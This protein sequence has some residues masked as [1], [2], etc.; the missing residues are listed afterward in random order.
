MEVIDGFKELHPSVQFEVSYFPFDDLQGR[1]SD[2]VAKGVGPT[3]LIGPAGW[4]PT[5]FDGGAIEDL[6]PLADQELLASINQAA[7]AQLKYKQALIGLPESFRRGVLMFRNNE[8]IPNPPRTLDELIEMA[9]QANHGEVVGADFDV[10]FY[11]SGAHLT[12]CGGNLV[13]EKGDPAF[14]S[15]AGVCWLKLLHSFKDSGL[16]VELNNDNDVNLFKA[17]R[18]GFLI[19]ESENITNLAEAI[20]EENLS[21]DPWPVTEQGHLSGFVETEAIYLNPTVKT[22]ND[23][24]A[25]AFIEYFL[26]P[27]AQAILADPAM[28][29]H[30]PTV[31]GV[32][33]PDRLMKETVIAFEKSIPLPVIPE[34]NAYWGPMEIA[35]Q[36]LIKEDVDPT[37][38]IQLAYI[39]IMTRIDEIRAGGN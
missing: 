1:Y 32:K 29:A 7:L 35:I 5:L 38:A 10:G 26:S 21:I 39:K 16:L 28:A 27:E 34:M 14:N 20:G 31:K 19:D 24:A 30:L 17:G 33:I 37:L 11:F 12:A 25:W 8:I 2:A 4:G 6:S 36:S 18:L 23:Q 13:D 3:L 15:E 9:T 22:N